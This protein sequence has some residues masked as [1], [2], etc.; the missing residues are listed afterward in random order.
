M[1]QK[2]G[3]EIY[4]TS[5]QLRG[6]GQDY[7]SSGATSGG[8]ITC[9]VSN[10]VDLTHVKKESGNKMMKQFED[11]R[12]KLKTFLEGKKKKDDWKN[13]HKIDDAEIDAVVKILEDSR[14][15]KF[16]DK[17]KV[18]WKDLTSEFK[19]E[20]WKSLYGSDSDFENLYN[21]LKGIYDALN[22]GSS[23]DDK[24]KDHLGGGS[25]LS[26]KGWASNMSMRIDI[27]TDFN[28]TWFK[29]KFKSGIL[30][31]MIY[32][33]KTDIMSNPNKSNGQ[34]DYS[35]VNHKYTADEMLPEEKRKLDSIQ[36]KMTNKVAKDYI[37]MLLG[38]S[39]KKEYRLN[40][41]GTPI[42]T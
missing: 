19:A 9:N 18:A 12:N 4:G 22:G 35:R 3:A 25:E 34:E 7:T 8:L 21:K 2:Y 38:W 11:I 10:F 31:K 42:P 30:N 24:G 5:A 28:E 20:N 16:N 33:V 29:R 39:R 36:W 17:F 6:Q 37:S 32:A 26:G 15:D 23:G 41:E 13:N 1:V 40:E 27:H 14:W